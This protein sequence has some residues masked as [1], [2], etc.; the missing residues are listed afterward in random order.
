[1]YCETA[2]KGVS[3]GQEGDVVYARMSCRR[4]DFRTYVSLY[5]A[6]EEKGRRSQERLASKQKLVEADCFSRAGVC[7]HC[8]DFSFCRPTMIESRITQ[9]CIGAGCM[10]ECKDSHFVRHVSTAVF[11]RMMLAGSQRYLV[12]TIMQR[13]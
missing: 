1:M 7:Q 3:R 6:D 12:S 9:R 2:V 11:E 10:F 8:I 5:R 13:A 4:G